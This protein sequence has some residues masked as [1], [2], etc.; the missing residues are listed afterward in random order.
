M[1]DI[2]ILIKSEP[3]GAL[4]HS[5]DLHLMC[6][7]RRSEKVGSREELVDMDADLDY[8]RARGWQACFADVWLVV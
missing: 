5:T 8:W 2:A 3:L 7:P 6:R 4:E 1:L